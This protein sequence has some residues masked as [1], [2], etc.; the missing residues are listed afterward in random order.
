MKKIDVLYVDDS[1]I[2]INKAPGMLVIPDRFDANKPC[3]KNIL[4]RSYGDIYIVHRLDYETSGVLIFGRTA[5]AHQHL[6]LQFA[7]G[8][9]TKI[10]LA[11]TMTPS[12]PSGVIDA[13]I[14][15]N[16]LARGRY[17]IHPKGKPSKTTYKVIERY[18]QY[19]LIELQLHT[20]R[21]H[22]IRVH[23]KHI[24]A[25]LIV[26]AKY[27]N[28]EAFYL[29]SIKRVRLAKHGE[30]KPLLHRS[31]LHSWKLT[32]IHPVSE[33]SIHFEAPMPKDM[34]AV[35]YQLNKAQLR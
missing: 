27:G 25:P 17:K 23:M 18:G 7:D 28:A 24:K 26:D 31:S 12:A 13:P 11:F 33:E 16:K 20:G 15:E 6:S 19:A 9:V 32:I 14:R 3:L 5:Q 10:Y 8:N 22:Q 1:I 29:S 2:A 30:E 21:S 4:S 35:Q 34:R